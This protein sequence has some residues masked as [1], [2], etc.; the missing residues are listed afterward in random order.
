M[1]EQVHRAH[2]EAQR[3]KEVEALARFPKENPSP[4]MRIG[5]DGAFQYLNRAAADV[6]AMAGWGPEEGAPPRWR[7]VIA[8]TLASGQPTEIELVA[9]ARVFACK[10]APVPEAAYVNIYALEVTERKSFEGRLSASEARK[11][12][13]LQ[14]ALDCIITIDHTGSIVEWNPAAEKTFGY[15]REQVL[16]QPMHEYIVPHSLRAAH[17]AGMERYL[18]TGHG[19][20]LG[21][22]IEITGLRAD[23]TEFPV[24]LAITPIELAGDPLFTAYLRD[25]TDRKQAEAAL[26]RSNDLMQAVSRTQSKFISDAGPTTLF[27]EILADVLALTDSEYGFVGE[28]L[29]T[30]AGDP[31][32]R[33]YAITDIAWNQE[34]RALYE[35]YAPTMEFYNL[36]TLFGAV[37]T[38][39][40]PVFANDP[41]TDSRSGGLPPGH[42]GMNSFLGLPLNHGGRM[43]GV[44][45]LANRPD[46]YDE[47][48]VAYLQPLLL[49]C[50]NI[51]GAYRNLR[52]RK[53]AEEETTRLATA[54]KSID[55]AIMITD[56]DGTIQDVNPAFERLTGYHA[57]TTSLVRIHAFSRAANMTQL[58]TNRCGR[59]S[60]KEISGKE[61][62]STD[63]VMAPSIMSKRP[64]RRCAMRPATPRPTWPLSAT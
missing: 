21:Q 32:M 38:T 30:D 36:K 11:A 23:G 40:Q 19:P 61:H 41:A 29:Y 18:R 50:G 8:Q 12:A 22:R 5:A 49:T 24:E 63:A 37:M 46:G 10:F 3:S 56:V 53:Q 28:V 55:E 6:L 25:I 17:Q 64:F 48:L 59:P 62:S 31:F 15:T 27:D 42:P 51:I 1:S 4:V 14:S 44:F 9:G 45:G 52:R 43:V 58:S 33:T 2:V 20:V 57:T 7:A 34:S 39:G 13:I 54:L 26:R 35:Q 60:D 47:P 16:G